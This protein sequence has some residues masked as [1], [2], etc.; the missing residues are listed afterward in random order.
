MS[1]PAIPPAILSPCTGVCT[2]DDEGYCAGCL[3]TGAE[4][5]GWASM[6]EPARMRIMEVVL[7]RREQERGH[8]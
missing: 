4:I 2:L 3:R 6:G 8:A 7:P 1:L 5:A